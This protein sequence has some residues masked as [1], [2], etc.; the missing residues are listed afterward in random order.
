MESKVENINL[1]NEIVYSSLEGILKELNKRIHIKLYA[2]VYNE[3]DSLAQTV[4]IKKTIASSGEHGKS[5][6]QDSLQD[7]SNLYG[8]LKADFSAVVN[9]YGG[10]KSYFD[11]EEQQPYQVYISNDE[12]LK[13]TTE[14]EVPIEQDLRVEDSIRDTKII[15]SNHLTFY[16]SQALYNVVYIVEVRNVE[17]EN[18]KLFY[19][20][21]EISFL[22][23]IMDYF[24]SDYFALDN[25]YNAI[26]INN[27]NQIDTKYNEDSL[28]FTRRLTRLFFGKM[29]GYLK[30]NTSL[31]IGTRY[32]NE[33]R[34]KYYVDNLLEKIDEIS[35]KTYEGASPFGSILFMNKECI[36][37]PL[38]IR[39]TVK[40]TKE[41]HIRLDDSKRIR[42]LLELTN[43]DK[44]LYLIADDNEIHGLGEVNWNLQKDALILKLDFNGISKYNLFLVRTD[45]ER[46]NYG[47]LLVSNDRK[48]Y[49]SDLKLL[50]TRLISVSFKNPRLGEEGYTPE[51]FINLLKSV[52]WEGQ[53]DCDDI[54]NQKLEKLDQIVRKSR[55]QKHG[56]MV[57]ITESDVAKFEVERLS[58]QS[59]LIEPGNINPEY[60]KFLTAIDGA[61]YFDIDGNCHA[62]GVIL[63]GIAKESIGDA[64]RGARYNSAHRYWH[65][66][67]DI[68][69]QNENGKCVIAI[70]SEDG[71]VDLIPESED[72][73]KLLVLTE[74]IIDSINEENLD[75]EKLKEKEEVLLQ[76]KII[77]CD[78]LFKVGEAYQ[79]KKK[80]AKAISFFEYGMERAERSYFQPEYFN[81]LGNCYWHTKDYESAI[82]MYGFAIT[83]TDDLKRK[84]VY[85]INIGNA[86]LELSHE[87]KKDEQKHHS[88]LNKAIDYLTE[89]IELAKTHPVQSSA[90]HYN[91]RAICY[92][93]LG[94]LTKAI[95][96]FTMALAE[97]PNKAVFLWNRYLVKKVSGDIIGSLEDII[98]A[99]FNEHNKDY[100]TQLNNLLDKNRHLIKEANT[101]YNRLA[102]QETE[103]S[104]LEI[105]IEKYNKAVELSSL[106]EDAAV[107]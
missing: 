30:D 22:R 89:G 43:V 95:D 58:K 72:E 77:D 44:D 33:L 50:E 20:E 27:N 19:H 3:K 73:G 10:I 69:K 97:E 23:M 68:N 46:S 4:R 76:S 80:Y 103:S 60:I 87:F 37:N 101:F 45:A 86:Y 38:L 81:V 98:E 75:T 106:T 6:S 59:T 94:D 79:L 29:Q 31:E 64:S 91:R 66:L 49:R 11:K 17:H 105:L 56:T 55:E 65:K 15:Y 34:S 5:V 102:G 82:K 47:E 25:Q 16:N 28:H 61:I 26:K 100:I 7:V 12:K 93:H 57:V 88:L 70:I 104:E 71:M 13:N 2:L 14:N 40:F 53:S 85:L 84:H 54:F 24:F 1:L 51:K 35:T 52:F 90:M 63:D 48:F 21:P 9:S 42:K 83:K 96:G 92:Y 78:W 8:E 74:E 18:R 67:K 41:D 62:I 99:E 32:D 39:F 107:K 36:R